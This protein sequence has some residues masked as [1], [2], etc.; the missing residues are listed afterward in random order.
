LN[1]EDTKVIE[2]N[3]LQGGRND[4]TGLD[5]RAYRPKI[6]GREWF[7]SE[8]DLE[9]LSCGCYILGTGGGGSPYPHFIRLKE[10]MRQG[11]I[12]RVI[13]P[14]DLADDALVG[15]GGNSDHVFY[16]QINAKI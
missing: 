12:V 9:F 2:K 10:M 11:A 4:K 5:I 16:L 13:D 6:V 14:N 1:G 3:P 15:C 8:L 7:I